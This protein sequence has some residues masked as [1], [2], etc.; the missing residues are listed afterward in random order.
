MNN[1][2]LG[3][4]TGW[5]RRAVMEELARV[6]EYLSNVGGRRGPEDGAEE[7][8]REIL[9][10]QKDRAVERGDQERAKLIWCYEQVLK[11]HH[12][13]MSA[14]SD[15]KRGLYYSAWCS[16]ERVEIAL[17]S[18]ERHFKLNNDEYKLRFIGK[19]V[20]QFQSLFPYKIF[21][22]PGMLVKEK[23]CSVCGTTVSVRNPCGHE[24]GQIYDGEMCYR[25][26]TEVEILEVSLVTTPG[27]KYAV[28]FVGQPGDDK[29]MKDH[30]NYAK[31]RYVV[32]G[33]RSPFDAWDLRWTERRHPHSRY[34]HVEQD[35]DCPCE[36]GEK[37]GD[38]CLSES[39]VLRPHLE[40]VFFVPPPKD[41][42]EIQYI[43]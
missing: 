24:V 19:H 42:L 16:F 29:Q 20:E 1:C 11:V 4:V 21:A 38:C 34:N 9:E 6:E 8:L 5:N 31:L 14:F 35:A 32:G 36:S 12:M 17:A 41:Q 27:H 25:H 37:Y 40:I 28:A 33:L 26:I 2:P 23:V 30:Y 10:V 13:Y 3:N 39:G 15:L 18:L 22:S 43:D 7:R